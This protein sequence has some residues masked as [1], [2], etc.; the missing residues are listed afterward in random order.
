[1][2][3]E[4]NE[5]REFISD[6]LYTLNAR[7]FESITDANGNLIDLNRCKGTHLLDFKGKDVK[8]VRNPTGKRSN[9]HENLLKAI[10]GSQEQYIQNLIKQIDKSSTSSQSKS[11]NNA[12]LAVC[13]PALLGTTFTEKTF[14]EKIV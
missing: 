1:M 11:Q 8:N 10:I 12:F 6:I 5:L 13:P 9:L 2:E 14:T 3:T 4:N 7:G